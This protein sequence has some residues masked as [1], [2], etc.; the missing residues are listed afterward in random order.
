M[1]ENGINIEFKSEVTGPMMAS[2]SRNVV[3]SS[4]MDT[5]GLALA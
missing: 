1:D 5:W 2:V 4:F 3:L